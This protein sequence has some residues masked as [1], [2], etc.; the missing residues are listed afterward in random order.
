[1]NPSG[2]EGKREPRG[3]LGVTR[4]E[5][6]AMESLGCSLFILST[7]VIEIYDTYKLQEI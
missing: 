5:G 7:A 3:G 1:M 2:E 4:R 6:E